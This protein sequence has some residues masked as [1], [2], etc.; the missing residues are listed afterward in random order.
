MD[1]IRTAARALTNVIYSGQALAG[2]EFSRSAVAWPPKPE[3]A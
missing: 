1:F 3:A 2:W